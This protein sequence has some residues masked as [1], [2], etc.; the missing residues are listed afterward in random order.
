[1]KPEQKSQ[2]L[3]G[4]TRSKAKMLEYG[5]PEEHH[6]QITQDPAKLFTLSIGILGDLGAHSNRNDI[7]PEELAEFRK[8]LHFSAHFFDAYLQ[9]RLN[10]KLDPYLILLGSASYYLCDLPGSSKVLAKQIGADCPNLGGEGLEELLLWLLQGDLSTYFDGSDGPFGEYID[11]ISRG[12]RWFFEDGTGAENL[13]ALSDRLRQEAYAIGT[14]RQLLLGDVVS[15]IVR[16]KHQNSSWHALPQY[17]GLTGDQWQPALQK[18]SFI[19]ELW[20][21]QHLLGQSEV[22]QGKSAVVQMPTSAGKTKATELII[23]SAFLANRTSLTIIVA[24][25]RALCHETKNSLF[26]AFQNE[27]INVDELSDVLQKDFEITELLGS[28]QILVVT[29]EKLLYALRHAPELAASVGLVIFDEGHQFD[30]GGTRGITYE[31]LITSLRSMLPKEAQKVLISAVI[32]NAQAVGE[33]LNG[34]ESKIVFGTNLMPTFRSVGFASWLDTL[35]R[36]EYVSNEN[37]EK[38]EFYVPRVIESF[39]LQRKPKERKDRVFPD[40]TD[41]HAIALFLGLKLV[42]NGSVAIFCGVKSTASSICEKA[43]DALERGIPAVLPADISDQEEMRRLHFLYAQNLG[44]E[45]SA[46]KSAQVG[47]FSHHGNT[48]HGIR[49]AVEHAMREELIRFVVCTST[50]AQGVNLPIR[51]LIVTSIYQGSER[52]KVR[53]FHNLIGRAGRAGMH[54]EG[55]VL[56]ADPVVYDKRE[57]KKEKW[58]WEKVK[59]LLDP[60]KS[61]ECNSSLFQLIPLVIRND[62]S[63]LKDKKEHTLSLDVLSFA[64]AYIGGWGALT[65]VIENIVQENGQNGFTEEK[66][67]SQ[68]EFFGQTLASIESF[69]MSNWD[70][71]D[72]AITEDGIIHLAE[73]TLAYFLADEEKRGQIRDLFKLLAE[74]IS[75]NVGDTKRRKVYGRTLYGTRD[76]QEIDDWVQANISQL[77]ASSTDD[78]ILNAV[79]PVLATHIHNSVFKKCDKPAVL[80]EIAKEWIQGKPFH[81]LFDTLQRGEAKLVWGTGRRQFKLEHVVEICE[82]GLAYDGALMIGAVIE[83]I[84]MLEQV[85]MKGLIKRLQLFQK[86]L[87]CGL[88]SEASIALYELGFSDRV[89]SQDLSQLNPRD[90]SKNRIKSK[91]RRTNNLA[92][93]LLQKYPAYFTSAILEGIANSNVR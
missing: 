51:Y 21:A 9:S 36:I 75:R 49:L 37:A 1:M 4:V 64:R 39:S 10:E 42:S 85:E 30:S 54:T 35:G 56:F 72:G 33:W 6:I 66:T 76:A 89:V 71:K 8:N 45:A 46:T 48:P 32:S 14:P 90:S 19:K 92:R 38:G 79:W 81:E 29:P 86:K 63:K 5:V 27:S 25:F 80:K 74:N 40:K 28:K 93:S 91:L 70:A 15:A 58:R 68:F 23:R 67:K 62:R 52:I 61:E 22:L 53:D 18:E 73:E 34:A 20:P 11:S 83:F 13:L 24:P 2:L 57:T 50:L 7:S 60:I 77:S 47:I 87:K 26:S 65:E 84:D 31:L 82:N 17:S 59:E 78:E 55:S 43:I 44:S 16:K 88:P 12:L 3:L 69:L 41:G